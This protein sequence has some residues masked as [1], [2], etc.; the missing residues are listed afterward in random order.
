MKD[1]GVY[2][3]KASHFFTT[4]PPNAGLSVA[5]ATGVQISSAN[6]LLDGLSP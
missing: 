2:E 4:S 3:R 1:E 6:T 5:E